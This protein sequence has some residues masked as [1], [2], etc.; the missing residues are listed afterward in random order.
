M[1]ISKAFGNLSKSL[2]LFL[3]RREHEKSWWIMENKEHTKDKLR[4]EG[5]VN[6]EQTQESNLNT[7]LGI[8]NR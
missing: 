1:A 6:M 2:S 4:R 5:M 7:V 3:P 8:M